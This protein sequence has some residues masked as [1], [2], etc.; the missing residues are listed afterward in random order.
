MPPSCPCPFVSDFWDLSKGVVVDMSP[1]SDRAKAFAAIMERK[2]S[3]PR[4]RSCSHCGINAD[5]RVVETSETMRV[6]FETCLRFRH[7]HRSDR[8]CHPLIQQWRKR[9]SYY[10]RYSDSDAPEQLRQP[11]GE[12]VPGASPV[13]GFVESA[14]FTPL[15]ASRLC[16]QTPH[17]G[18]KNVGLAG[19][20]PN[21]RRHALCRCR[22]FLS[23]SFRH[24]SS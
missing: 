19:R 18:I 8:A 14:F 15:R 22:E 13:D 12:F 3:T 17:A 5:G 23:T 21:R 20:F 16:V 7:D 9:S 1:A 24:P 11:V 4:R 2:A 10:W 6:S